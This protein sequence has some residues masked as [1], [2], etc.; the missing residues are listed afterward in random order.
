M[1]A[2]AFHWR[3]KLVSI[4]TVV[5][6]VQRTQSFFPRNLFPRAVIMFPAFSTS[7][8]NSPAITSVTTE[9]TFGQQLISDL[10]FLVFA[11]KD[12]FTSHQWHSSLVFH[13][14]YIFTAFWRFFLC[15]SL[16]TPYVPAF[17]THLWHVFPRFLLP[18][19][20]YPPTLVWASR[21]VW[22]VFSC[23]G[24]SAMLILN[25]V[26]FSKLFGVLYKM[27]WVLEWETKSCRILVSA[28]VCQQKI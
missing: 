18:Y 21:F 25:P 8:V 11:S 12:M 26:L 23:D 17:A 5:F 20:F 9:F 2:L 15:F 7:D 6:Y 1:N 16:V 28:G 22:F 3:N 13:H 19:S 24:Q 10:F 4:T 27:L 14:W